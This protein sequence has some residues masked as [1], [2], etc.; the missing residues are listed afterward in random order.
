MHKNTKNKLFRSEFYYRNNEINDDVILEEDD[1]Q[2]KN[3]SCFWPIIDQALGLK[4][5]SS[6]EMQIS[7]LELSSLVDILKSPF[8]FSLFIEKSDPTAKTYLFKY[9]KSSHKVSQTL[10]QKFSI[11]EC[12]IM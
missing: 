11:Y 2:L 1:T 12:K 5:C 10:S 3:I 6:H 7:P 8:K 4:L 9:L